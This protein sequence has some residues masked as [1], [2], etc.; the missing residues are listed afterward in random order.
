MPVS[1]LSIGVTDACDLKPGYA[2][3]KNDFPMGAGNHDTTFGTDE[4]VELS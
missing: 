1:L 4:E 3:I 2:F